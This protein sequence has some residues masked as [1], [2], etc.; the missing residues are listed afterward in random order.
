MVRVRVT[1]RAMNMDRVRIEVWGVE[2]WQNE[3]KPPARNLK[4]NYQT[5]SGI[6]YTPS[7]KQV[8]HAILSGTARL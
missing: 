4:E 1:D 2:I 6:F 7:H 3:K 8:N 5:Q